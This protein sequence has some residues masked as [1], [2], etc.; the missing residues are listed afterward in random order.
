M[1]VTWYL[2]VF[3]HGAEKARL[4]PSMMPFSGFCS[5]K[6]RKK[7]GIEEEQEQSARKV[8][9]LEAYEPSVPPASSSSPAYAGARLPPPALAA[10]RRRAMPERDRPPR[11]AAGARRRRGQRAA[12]AG[13]I[14][15]RLSPA[16]PKRDVEAEDTGGER[17][18]QGYFGQKIE[19]ANTR[20]G[21][22]RK[23]KDQTLNPPRPPPLAAAAKPAGSSH[24]VASGFARWPPDLDCSSLVSSAAALTGRAAAASRRSFRTVYKAKGY[25][26]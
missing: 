4:N 24:C 19:A 14:S 6:W 22:G 15:K 16:S 26:S 7:R 8:G 2:S 9:P 3:G 20:E 10:T 1:S 21:E 11:R 23:P 12:A 5:T 18:G 13:G 25:Y 17:W